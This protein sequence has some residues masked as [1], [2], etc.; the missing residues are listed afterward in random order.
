MCGANIKGSAQRSCI[1]G[2]SPLVRGKQS[3][4]T[5]KTLSRL[6]QKIG[7][8]QS[9][10]FPSSLFDAPSSTESSIPR[11]I[12]PSRAPS[13]RRSSGGIILRRLLGRPQDKLQS[14]IIYRLPCLPIS[15]EFKPLLSIRGIYHHGFP[16]LQ[17]LKDLHPQEISHPSGDLAPIHPRRDFQ[18]PSGEMST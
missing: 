11:R 1:Y 3:D 7:F 4:F 16:F 17:I 5:G 14:I 6:C 12:A 10:H 2:S 13:A 15:L 8:A 18:Q 9:A